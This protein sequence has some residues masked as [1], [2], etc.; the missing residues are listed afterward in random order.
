MSLSGRYAGPYFPAI[1]ET[2]TQLTLPTKFL[3]RIRSVISYDELNFGNYTLMFISEFS[4][5]LI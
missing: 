5:N 1:F 4:L 3:K 2:S